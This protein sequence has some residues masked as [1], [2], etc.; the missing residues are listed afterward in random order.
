[1]NAEYF[2]A[3]LCGTLSRMARTMLESIKSITHDDH[4]YHGTP[5]DAACDALEKG[6]E[7]ADP[8]V[9]ESRERVESFWNDVVAECVADCMAHPL[10]KRKNTDVVLDHWNMQIRHGYPNDV[11]VLCGGFERE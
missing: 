10:S 1:M 2:H 4:T 5:I 8:F 9:V 7:S 11:F 3:R 6:T